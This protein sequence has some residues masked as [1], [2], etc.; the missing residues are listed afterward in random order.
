MNHSCHAHGC[1]KLVPA[2]LF[3]CPSHWRKLSAP[4]RRAIWTEY[5]EGQEVKKNPTA[6]YLCVQQ[7]AIAELAFKPNDEQAAQIA[8]HY[9][10]ESEKWRQ[11]AIETGAGDPLRG[12]VQ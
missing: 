12:V 1:L 10:G 3:V 8:A 5:R 4:L 11:A 9:L 2:R 7:R 6:R